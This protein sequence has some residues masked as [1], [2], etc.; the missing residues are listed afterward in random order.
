MNLN[1][2]A[3]KVRGM[4]SCRILASLAI[5]FAGCQK[6]ATP[7]P[8]PRQALHVC[9]WHY[10]PKDH[11][12]ADL[13]SAG[14][15]QLSAEDLD[16]QYSEFLAEVEAVQAEQVAELRKLKLWVLSSNGESVHGTAAVG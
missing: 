5:L 6:T 2:F 13:K 16:A 1:H 10:V 7:P 4:N 8:L 12:A 3:V 11:F 15:G 14:D 9:N